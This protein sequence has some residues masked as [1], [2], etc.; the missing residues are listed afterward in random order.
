MSFF[1]L[2]VYIMFL[3]SGASALIYQVA[4]V[5]SLS[6]IF[7][8]SHLAVTVVLSTF[9]AGLALGGYIIGRYSD[10]IKNSLRFY[11]FLELGIAFSAL[12]FMILMSLYPSLYR[13]IAGGREDSTFFLLL[14]R[15]LFSFFALIIPTTFMGGTLPVLTRFVS[16]QPEDVRG[17]LSFLYS[18]NTFGAIIGAFLAGFVL[19]PK[20]PVSKTFYIAISVNIL[21]GIGSLLISKTK[22]SE[23]GLLKGDD[24]VVLGAKKEDLF[25]RRLILIGIGIS[26]FCALGYEVLWTR[27]LTMVVGASVYSFTAMLVAFLSGIALGSGAFG[28]VTKLFNL[29]DSTLKGSFFSFGIVQTIIGI[30]ALIVT[31]Y[32]RDLPVNSINLQRLFSDNRDLFEVRQWA[33]LLLAF[34]YMFVPAFFMG[35][36]FPMA[37]RIYA[38]LTGK[39]G[40]A[41]G[42]VLAFNTIGAILGAAISGLF[43]IYLIGIERGLQ[44]LI[45]INIGMGG[46]VLLS[47]SGKKEA[48]L[49]SPITVT[50]LILYLLFNPDSIRLWDS[51]YF[52]IFRANQPEAF[53]TPEMIK[54]AKE[55]TDVLY[56]KEGVE[57]TVSSIKIRGG[58]QAFLTNGRVEASD[59]LGDLQV[60][61]T[62]GHLPMLLHNN[63][64]DVLVIGLGSGVTVGAT[65]IHPEAKSIT[66]IELAPEVIGVAKTF[67]KYNHDVISNPKV[68]I[69]FNDGRNHLLI[70]KK[71]YD[72]ITADPIHPWFRG[73]GYLYTKE[74][75]DLASKRLKKGGIMC[76]WLPIYELTLNDLQSIMKTFRQSF[77]YTMLW[78][79]YYDSVMIGSNEPILIDEH[80]IEKRLSNPL[81][82]ADL[83]RVK[84]GSSWDLLSY[85]GM[86]SIKMDEFSKGG[87]INTD[88]NLYLEFSAPLSMGKGFLMKDNL[89][90]LI[91]YREDLIPYMAPTD[92]LEDK[93]EREQIWKTISNAFKYYDLAHILILGG[94]YRR[95]EFVRLME[96]LE[97]RYPTFAPGRFLKAEYSEL[98]FMD[99]K[100]L[101]TASFFFLDIT[102]ELSYMELTAVIAPVSREKMAVI[103]A[104][105]NARKIYGQTFFSGEEMEE[106]I[107]RFVDDTLLA[108]QDAYHKEIRL[109]QKQGKKYPEVIKTLNIM[110]EVI[111]EKIKKHEG[112]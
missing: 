48:S 99:P 96:A 68:K 35:V 83:E 86:G 107:K 89:E 44:I 80:E 13:I 87:V 62:L 25:F 81:I 43:L 27:V 60:Q 92:N 111:K 106:N 5:R 71:K 98:T 40:T 41:V 64:Q 76:Q 72:V 77:K 108:L 1:L 90:V 66:L 2:I 101:K 16:K 54:E 78:L 12:L 21:I 85:F 26:G 69:I 18:F 7:G 61:Y 32:I 30:T 84:M 103:F 59:H 17:Y 47:L 11:G 14:V 51:K 20:I 8:G 53:R 4:W 57:A 33:N 6:L 97:R 58:H 31:I 24:G 50:A 36:A 112:E 104:D 3:L 37:G 19:L 109:A 49:L 42:D 82:K 93:E 95:P 52:A 15:L 102:G 74:Y 9:M 23:P 28:L 34:L 70:T 45:L 56:F 55:N 75:F 10:R 39:I 79:I 65:S 94:E 88:D 73:A 46:F 38:N 110:R 91:R 105:N 29:R 22:P 100:P 63:P 67:S